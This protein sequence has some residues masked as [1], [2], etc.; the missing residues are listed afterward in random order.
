MKNDTLN[1]ELNE[2]P[3]WSCYKMLIAEDEET[4]FI[5]TKEIL[6]KT[7]IEILWAKNGKEAIEYAK[8]VNDIDFIL[9]DIKMP[10]INGIEAVKY[11]LKIRPD[12]PIIAHTAFAMDN[13]CEMLLNIGCVD[14][15]SKPINPDK[16]FSK[17]HKLLKTK[18]KET[19]NT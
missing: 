4:N 13:D 14:Y 2:F 17:L 15:I 12:M 18:A 7:G 6:S 19:S 8:T 1:Y 16:L 10:E 11:I 9:M 3:D 5:Y